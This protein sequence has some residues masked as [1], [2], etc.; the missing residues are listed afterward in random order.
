MLVLAFDTTS[1]QG[2]VGLYRDAECLVLLANQ[3]PANL[4]SVTLFEMVDRAL[5]QA[6]V[7]LRDVELFAVATGP[8]SF[9]G[10][11]VGL[12]AAQAWATAFGRPAQG[13][14]I[15]EAMVAEARPETE[16]AVPILD[17]RRGEFF[18]GIFERASGSS[19][20]FF[21]ES[22]VV[23]KPSSL[24]GYLEGLAGNTLRAAV[25]CVV[26]EHDRLALGLRESLAKSLGWRSVSGPLVPA[27]A[28]LALQAY[29]AGRVQSPH[30]LDAYYI[31]RSDAEILF[32][33][34]D[35]R[36]QG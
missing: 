11:R 14:S 10:I 3:G 4:Y 25:T 36:R 21:L 31:R 23:L 6:K 8:G 18:V 35:D 19:N 28:R 24:P 7:A 20:R 5:E 16:W 33:K 1:E 22:H 29:K 34:A 15:L 9:T 2:G 13:I 12:A 17:A 30:E 32:R 27:I 26:R